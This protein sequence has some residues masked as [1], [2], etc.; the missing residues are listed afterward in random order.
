MKFEISNIERVKKM[1]IPNFYLEENLRRYFNTVVHLTH[2]LIEK[3]KPKSFQ[4][5]VLF[6]REYFIKLKL[7]IEQGVNVYSIISQKH[8]RCAFYP[9]L[10]NQSSPRGSRF[11]NIISAI[12]NMIRFL[13]ALEKNQDDMIPPNQY[14][15]DLDTIIEPLV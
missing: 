15:R 5:D 7:N 3:S 12:E 14:Y 1:D 6:C 9:D 2:N 10:I 8:N 11:N 4:N 13:D